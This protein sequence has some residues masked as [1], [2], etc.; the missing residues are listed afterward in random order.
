[1]VAQGLLS[2]EEGENRQ[3]QAKASGE[4]FLS[5]LLRNRRFRADQIAA[6]AAVTFGFPFLNLDS[7]DPAVLPKGVVDP[8]LLSKHRVLPIAQRGNR[9]FIGVSDPSNL[10]ALDDIKFQSNLT[11]EPIVVEDDKLGKLL[12]EYGQSTEE[13]ILKTIDT[14][15]L[16]LEFTDDE[17]QEKADTAAAADIDD[18]PVV[19]YL[20]KIMMDA[21]QSGASDIHFEPYE[22]NYRHL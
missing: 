12:E 19:K 20:Q 14:E 16:N 9:L 2:Q 8:K 3:N 22:K 1:M 4:T 6:F 21:I 15:D 13:S 7:V 11:V 17:A 5:H 10:Q 18:A